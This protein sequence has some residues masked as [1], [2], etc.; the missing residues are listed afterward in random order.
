MTRGTLAALA[1]LAVAACHGPEREPPAPIP[2]TGG[3]A[4]TGLLVI[5]LDTTRADRIGAY[6]H[7]GARTPNV[8]GLGDRGV[9]FE[10]ALTPVPLNSARRASAPGPSSVPPCC[11][12]GPD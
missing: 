12:T 7:R 5:T 2:P 1:C 10:V 8:D 11:V 9:L 3:E 4:P 6:G